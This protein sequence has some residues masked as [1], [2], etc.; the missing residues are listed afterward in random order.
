MASPMHMCL[1][2]VYSLHAHPCV[3]DGLVSCLIAILGFK[4][5]KIAERAV[6]LDP[7]SLAHEARESHGSALLLMSLNQKHGHRAKWLMAAAEA[8][9]ILRTVWTQR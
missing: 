4:P 7:R 3:L 1:L 6:E 2:S 9:T 5:S 8:Y